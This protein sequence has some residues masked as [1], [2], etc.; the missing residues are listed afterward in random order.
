MSRTRIS[1]KVNVLGPIFLTN[2]GIRTTLIII[3]SIPNTA[4]T[5]KPAPTAIPRPLAPQIIAAVVKPT[6]TSFVFLRITPAPKN[7]TPL[8]TCAASRIGSITCKPATANLFADSIET[9]VNKQL[10]KQ[11]TNEV[12]RPRGLFLI[13]LSKPMIMPNMEE[14]PNLSK[15]PRSIAINTGTTPFHLES[16]SIIPFKLVIFN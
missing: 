12:L 5:K 3:S 7:P 6:I 4:S 16:L 1:F 10:L 2:I 13:S 9:I 15:I 11:I 14:M 8:T